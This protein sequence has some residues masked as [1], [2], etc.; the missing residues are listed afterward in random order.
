M[1]RLRSSDGIASGLGV[2][3]DLP[4]ANFRDLDRSTGQLGLELLETL[5][6]LGSLWNKPLFFRSSSQFWGAFGVYD[7]FVAIPGMMSIRHMLSY[8]NVLTRLQEDLRREEI[9]DHTLW[10]HDELNRRQF[11]KA[12]SL[13][14]R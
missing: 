6:H 8:C 12:V 9:E 13:G 5:D 3:C 10:V 1:V 7:I 11:H 4:Q 2:P 14:L